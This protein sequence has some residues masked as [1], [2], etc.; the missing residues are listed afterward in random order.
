MREA[1]RVACVYMCFRFRYINF[2]SRV[3]LNRFACIIPLA[4]PSYARQSLAVSLSLS[5]TRASAP[6]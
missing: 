2:R 6:S 1:R 5:P 3:E 4:S